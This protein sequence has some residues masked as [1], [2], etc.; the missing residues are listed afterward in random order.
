MF[1]IV[2]SIHKETVSLTPAES[3]LVSVIIVASL[4][5]LRNQVLGQTTRRVRFPADGQNITD[6]DVRQHVS[7]VPNDANV[8]IRALSS[9]VYASDD[10]R[11]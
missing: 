9:G 7:Y 3:R 2:G 4:A 5:L 8:L 10:G 11:W 1:S 6:V